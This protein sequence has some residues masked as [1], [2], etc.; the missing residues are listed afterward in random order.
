MVDVKGR[1]SRSRSN[2]GSSVPKTVSVIKMAAYNV[3]R[4]RS[5][6]AL[7]QTAITT[8]GLSKTLRRGSQSGSKRS[9]SRSTSTIKRHNESSSKIIKKL[10]VSKTK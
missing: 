2:I 8:A 6:G 1:T 3:K 10:G 7:N 4:S 9:L 5:R